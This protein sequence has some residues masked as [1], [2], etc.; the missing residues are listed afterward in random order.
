MR[1]NM[2]YIIAA[3][4]LVLLIAFVV[5]RTRAPIASSEVQS[6]DTQEITLGETDF[7]YYPN[8]ITVKANQPVELTLDKSVTGCL[9]AFVIKDLGVN[10]NSKSPAEKITFTPTKK[11]KFKFACVMGMGYGTIIVE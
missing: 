11:G 9:R 8:T 1:K 2:F 5:V 3:V 6:T 10:K 4:L 7:N